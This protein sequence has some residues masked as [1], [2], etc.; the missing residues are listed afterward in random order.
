MHE[1][2]SLLCRIALWELGVK[3]GYGVIKTV[4][5]CN[6]TQHWPSLSLVFQNSARSKYQNSSMTPRLSGHFSIFG[7]VFFVRKSLLGIASQQSRKKFAILSPKPRSRVR[8]LIYRTRAIAEPTRPHRPY[9][10]KW[11]IVHS[12]H[13]WKADDLEFYQLSRQQQYPEIR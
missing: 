3:K 4:P 11:S 2:R 13:Y 12:I 7:F 10:C 6:S 9:L 5:W 1:K 8:I